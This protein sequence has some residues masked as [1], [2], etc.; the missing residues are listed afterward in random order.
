MRCEI[1]GAPFIQKEGEKE[2]KKCIARKAKPYR[3]SSPSPPSNS[4]KKHPSSQKTISTGFSRPPVPIAEEQPKPLIN[5]TQTADPIVE[6]PSSRP[7][8][9]TRSS[10]P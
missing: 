5:E 1:C 10:L 4:Q 2:C 8:R 6:E 3:P 9:P 7:P